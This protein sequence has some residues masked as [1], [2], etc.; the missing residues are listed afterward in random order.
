MARNGNAGHAFAIASASVAS[1]APISRDQGVVIANAATIESKDPV[2][3][4]YSLVNSTSESTLSY[5]DGRA[6]VSLDSND[7]DATTTTAMAFQPNADDG[8]DEASR[9]GSSHSGCATPN[10]DSSI[11]ESSSSSASVTT[12]SSFTLSTVK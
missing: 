5:V 10:P 4:S 6:N 8:D 7:G 2:R 12:S 3:T 11:D 9:E 1:V